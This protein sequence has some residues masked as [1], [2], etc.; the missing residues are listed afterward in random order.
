V[1]GEGQL[2]LCM[3]KVNNG[4]IWKLGK[5]TMEI[6]KLECK[7]KHKELFERL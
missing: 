1:R 3:C 4:R 2:G 5:I 6:L 7:R